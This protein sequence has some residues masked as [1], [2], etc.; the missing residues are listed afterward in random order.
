VLVDADGKEIATD[1]QSPL[2]KHGDWKTDDATIRQAAEEE[3]CFDIVGGN[4]DAKDFTYTL[5]ARKT[6]GREGFLIP[7]HFA[8][9]RNFAF[10][11]IGGWNNTRHAIEVTKDGS[12]SEIGRPVNGKIETGKWYDIKIESKNDR[13][14]CYLDGK[15]V[16]D[17]AYPRAKA[18]FAVAGQKGGDVIVKVANLGK[19]PHETQI[20]L[21][22]ASGKLVAKAKAVVLTSASPDDENSLDQPTKVAP[23]ESSV[24]VAAEGTI[25]HTFPP[26]SVTVLSV[27]AATA[28]SR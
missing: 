14:Q 17:I 10:W 7:I 24:D 23:A 21:D 15:L 4:V 28:A 16:H 8:D 25:A 26:Y 22:G 13:L 1:T 12:K 11:N 9:E 18:L 27:P 20:R 19:T 5:K 2:F 3:G 6:A